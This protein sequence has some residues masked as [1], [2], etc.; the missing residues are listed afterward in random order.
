ML[1]CLSGMVQ[2]VQSGLDALTRGPLHGDPTPIN[3]AM[4][5]IGTA[6][7]IILTSYVYIKS[8]DFVEEQQDAISPLP[9]RMPLIREESYLSHNGGT[10]GST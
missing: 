4:A 2:F 7:G 9:E 8:R 1:I 6:I 10:Y 3:I 5:V